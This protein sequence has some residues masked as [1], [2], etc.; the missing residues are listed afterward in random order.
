MWD[1]VMTDEGRVYCAY[2]ILRGYVMVEYHTVLMGIAD[3]MS[4]HVDMSTTRVEDLKP[5]F[6]KLPFTLGLTK[7]LFPT[8]YN[9]CATIGIRDDEYLEI[10]S[11]TMKDIVV[12]KILPGQRLFEYPPIAATILDGFFA[13]GVMSAGTYFPEAVL[14]LHSM[15]TADEAVQAKVYA[16]WMRKYFPDAWF[17]KHLNWLIHAAH[18]GGIVPAT[19][20]NEL[21]INW[22]LRVLPKVGS[23][24]LGDPLRLRP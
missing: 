18:R 4:P 6:D 2:L 24:E 5:L 14:E 7:R 22:L 12:M 19:L 17:G 13:V 11:N 1:G 23:G 10:V 16:E 3:Q 20:Q 8:L 9:L 21:F 15:R